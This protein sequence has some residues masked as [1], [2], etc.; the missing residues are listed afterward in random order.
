MVTGVTEVDATPAVRTIDTVRMLVWL[1]VGAS[2]LVLGLV[3][4]L[5][6]AAARHGGMHFHPF[7]PNG[8]G[9]VDPKDLLPGPG[10]V[11]TVPVGLYGVLGSVVSLML[12]VWG[13]ALLAVPAARRAL[14]PR[15]LALIAACSALLAAHA[16]II[17]AT[18]FG[19]DVV[20]WLLD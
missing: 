7:D 20:T 6:L 11:L 19:G 16:V 10:G 4:L 9:L 1:Q 15:R 5:G 18:P 8:P 3:G 2:V 14:S 17:L 13:G 12:A